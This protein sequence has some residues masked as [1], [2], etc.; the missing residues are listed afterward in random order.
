MNTNTNS[1][2]NNKNSDGK[3]KVTTKSN[4]KTISNKQVI[5]VRKI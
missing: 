1:S 4:Q 5:N 3:L 2:N